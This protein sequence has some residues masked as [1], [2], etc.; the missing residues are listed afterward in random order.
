VD[1]ASK[2]N[3]GAKYD[4]KVFKK[5]VG[6]N[7]VGIK[8]VNA[9]SSHFDIQSFR[10]GKMKQAEFAAG[11]LEK[12]RKESPSEL[13]NGTLIS[14]VPDKEMFGN[15]HYIL[16]YIES[17]VKNYVYLNAGL[18][19]M[20]NGEKY[21]SKNGLLD[22]LNENLSAR[23]PECTRTVSYYTSKESRHRTGHDTWQPVYR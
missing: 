18:T 14:F 10:E 15:Y 5:S 9:L 2:M 16:E 12:E 20:V 11:I 22:L 23:E 6:L 19:I 4:S 8:A 3:T 13:D 7:G 17:L 1:V 21:V